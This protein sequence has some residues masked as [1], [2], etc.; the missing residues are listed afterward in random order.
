[1]NRSQALERRG[2][3]SEGMGLWSLVGGALLAVLAAGIIV[4]I[5]DIKRYLKIRNM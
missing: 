1:M 4:S 5:P 3:R 2:S